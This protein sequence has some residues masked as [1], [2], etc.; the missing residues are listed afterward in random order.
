MKKKS[1]KSAGCCLAFAMI[2]TTWAYFSKIGGV[3]KREF[4][5]SQ[6]DRKRLRLLKVL[7]SIDL[8]TNDH[9]PLETQCEEFM[10]FMNHL[11]TADPDYLVRELED[12]ERL[13][14]HAAFLHSYRY[15]IHPAMYHRVYDR[16]RPYLYVRNHKQYGIDELRRMASLKGVKNVYLQSRWEV[17]RHLRAPSDRHLRAPERIAPETQ[18][19]KHE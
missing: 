3:I 7:R 2:S 12:M 15:Q 8:C 5:E 11:Y 10:K 18:I 19:C 13:F 1:I 16:I 6:K 9:L 4:E 17:A 14:S